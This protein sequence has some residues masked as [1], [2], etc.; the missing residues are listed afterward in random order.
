M[1]LARRLQVHAE[2]VVFDG[3][4][5]HV[6]RVIA[7]EPAAVLKVQSRVH[8]HLARNDWVPRCNDSSVIEEH[9]PGDGDRPV[10]AAHRATDPAHTF[11]H[12][13]QTVRQ[14]TVGKDSDS[15]EIKLQVR[16]G[17]AVLR[18]EVTLDFG[19][20]A[21]AEYLPAAVLKLDIHCV[22]IG[23]DTAGWIDT[24]REPQNRALACHEFE[25][26]LQILRA[27]REISR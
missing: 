21:E 1:T 25:M 23:A 2:T 19:P 16:L 11:P 12:P 18:T 10:A 13:E 5:L 6:Y 24:G 17:S 27:R 15:C 26:Q 7:E 14:D 8:V 4:P 3:P 9:F 22:W 20:A